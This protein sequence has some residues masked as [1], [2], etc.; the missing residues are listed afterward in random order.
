MWWTQIN[1]SLPIPLKYKVWMSKQE[2]NCFDKYI[3]N[4]SS[5]L[6]FGS[7]GSTIRAL[8]KS[9]CN[10][11]SVESDNNWINELRTYNIIKKAERSGRL[12]FSKINIGPVGDRGFP[13]DGSFRP[14]FPRY[15]SSVFEE[16]D[17]C[18]CILIDGRFRIAC[19][20]QTILNIKNP[21]AAILFHD[22]WAR[23]EYH[24]VLQYL[25]EIERIGSMGVFKIFQDL[26]QDDLLWNYERYKYQ[27]I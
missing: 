5:Y 20:L 10:I 12:K 27:P 16:F 2:I 23:R 7:G 18:D 22:I 13:M 25:T 17:S 9:K 1:K 11:L 6:E 3:R 8:V 26:N 4:A 24:V 19:T 14:E 15:S 21:D